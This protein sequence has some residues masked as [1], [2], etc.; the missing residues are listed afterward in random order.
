[1]QG[2]FECAQLES[3]WQL[4]A[5]PPIFWVPFPFPIESVLLS[6]N[7]FKH[8]P[9]LNHS[10]FLH[11]DRYLWSN[12]ENGKI[13]SLVEGLDKSSLIHGTHEEKFS[14]DSERGKKLKKVA[15]VFEE[16]KGHH[17]F[18]A[19]KFYFCE[20][21]TLVNLIFQYLVTDIFLHD[22]FQI[23]ALGGLNTD[24]HVSMMPITGTCR[25]C[26]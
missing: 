4:T 7:N 19:W 1:M 6:F 18:W 25:Y 17:D 12:W 21:L 26:M 16:M 15:Q 3:T 8:L 14:K 13:K 11:I 5:V 23:V 2:K 9:T 20:F 22:H 24:E 10:P